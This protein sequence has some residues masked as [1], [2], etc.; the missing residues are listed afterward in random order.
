MSHSRRKS[1]RESTTVGFDPFLDLVV[2]VRRE[3]VGMTENDIAKCLVLAR[4]G[5]VVQLQSDIGRISQC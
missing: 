4:G 2:F 3:V 1:L 5:D